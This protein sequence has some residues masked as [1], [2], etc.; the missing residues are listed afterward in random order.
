MMANLNFFDISIF[1]F[2]ETSRALCKIASEASANSAATSR[3]GHLL[4]ISRA[5]N[6]SN[7]FLY[8]RTKLARLDFAAVVKRVISSSFVFAFEKLV[9][10][11]KTD[12][13]S[14]KLTR[15]SPSPLEEPK[16]CNKRSLD[17]SF[18]R[19][20]KNSKFFLSLIR[21][22]SSKALSGSATLLR[23]SIKTS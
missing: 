12:A 8:S 16:T 14:G 9:S 20:F 13:S 6:P 15:C 4:Q 10:C 19:D 11:K 2:N 21:T 23:F 5:A 22:S 17:S 3:K 18:S 1:L 7:T